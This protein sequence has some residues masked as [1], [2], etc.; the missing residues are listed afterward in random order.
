PILQAGL[1]LAVALRAAAVDR[2][3]LAVVA[4][5][6]ALPVVAHT[7]RATADPA[8]GRTQFGDRHLRSGRLG[9]LT[10]TGLGIMRRRGVHHDS[11]S[12]AC[13]VSNRI[14]TDG[15]HTGTTLC[16]QE[17]GTADRSGTLPLG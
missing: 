9:P 2:F 10:G 16:C 5:T 17:P 14:N 4:H 1:A 3:A 7:H 8:Q 11:E 15:E 6:H 12:R 13:S